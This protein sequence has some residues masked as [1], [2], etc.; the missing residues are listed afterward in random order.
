MSYSDP[1][2]DVLHEVVEQHWGHLTGSALLDEVDLRLG[3]QVSGN[4]LM[5]FVFERKPGNFRLARG[6]VR[7]RYLCPDSD[8]VDDVMEQILGPPQQPSSA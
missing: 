8:I 7:A 2:L 4:A 5:W 3:D 6:L 1:E